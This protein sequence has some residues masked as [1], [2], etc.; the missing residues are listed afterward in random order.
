MKKDVSTFCRRFYVTW[1]IFRE[2]LSK[3]DED[4]KVN[5]YSINNIKI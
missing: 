5:G 3:V 1:I 2:V 4:I